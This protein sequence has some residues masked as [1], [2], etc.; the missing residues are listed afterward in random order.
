LPP[1]FTPGTLVI[2]ESTSEVVSLQSVPYLGIAHSTNGHFLSFSPSDQG[3]RFNFKDVVTRVFSGPRTILTLLTTATASQGEILS[4]PRPANHSSYKLNFFGPA[5]RC[6]QANATTVGWIDKAIA[7]EMEQSATETTRQVETAYHAFVP[8]SFPDH[9]SAGQADVRFQS[10]ANASN[11]V[12]MAFERYVNTTDKICDHQKYYQVCSLWNATYDLT[13]NWENDFQNVSGSWNLL[14]EVSYPPV[15]PANTTTE[16]TRHAYSAFFWALANQLV[17]T[18]GQFE[19]KLPN[20][21]KSRRF[22]LIRCPIQHTSLLG[23]CPQSAWLAKSQLVNIPMYSLQ[24]YPS[25][26]TTTRIT[27]LARSLT[28]TSRDRGGRMWIGHEEERWESSSRS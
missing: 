23:V 28:R 3:D 1:F 12:W 21:S 13:L 6:G 15:D 9:N 25:S 5:V 17:G 18:F 27:M 16:M 8:S 11:E 4:L 14:H 22:P 2:Y 24:I 10:P 26:L 7:A 20:G 19:E